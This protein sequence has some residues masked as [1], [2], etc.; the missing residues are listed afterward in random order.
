MTLAQSQAAKIAPSA[1]EGRLAE[2][3]RFVRCHAIAS[4]TRAGSGHPGGA[5]SGGAGYITA[6]VIAEDL[7]LK[8]WWKPWN[9]REALEMLPQLEKGAA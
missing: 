1:L 4:I 9:A 6:S 3:A 2:A 7:G 5:I 8:P